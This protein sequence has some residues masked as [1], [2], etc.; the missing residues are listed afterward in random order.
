[1]ASVSEAANTWLVI[2]RAS[3]LKWRAKVLRTQASYPTPGAALCGIKVNP[4]IRAAKRK[5]SALESG[6]D[7]NPDQVTL[8]ATSLTSPSETSLT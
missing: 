2:P 5:I 7:L 1:M 3:H 4:N 6:G 8:I